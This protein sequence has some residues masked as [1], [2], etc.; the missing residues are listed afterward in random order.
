MRQ[1]RKNYLAYLEQIRWQGTPKCPYCTS[2]NSTAI[3]KESRYHCNTCFNSYSVTVGTLFHKTYVDLSKWFLAI[4][5]IF[6]SQDS[7]SARQLA[8]KIGVN[9]NTAYSMIARI[10]KAMTEE[11]ELLKKIAQPEEL[12]WEPP[13]PPTDLI[14]GDGEPLETNRHRIAM[15]TLICSLQQKQGLEQGLRL[16]AQ[17]QL[18]R[19]L[20]L[21][22]GS[23]PEDVENHLQSLD[24][25]QLEELVEVAL[26]AETLIGFTASILNL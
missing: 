7:L 1:I 13:M 9:K 15:N 8:K 6:N 26:K 17:R 20:T 4:S 18:L 22:F 5:L 14:F 11:P 16:G 10:R 12:D 19:L 21:R 24:S 2:T 3:E 23:V 25:N